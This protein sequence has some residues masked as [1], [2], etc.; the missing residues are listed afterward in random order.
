MPCVRKYLQLVLAL[1]LADHELLVEAI[2]P[3][4][5]QQLPALRTQELRAESQ[6][7]GVPEGRCG[8]EVGEPSP[9]PTGGLQRGGRRE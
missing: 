4:E 9:G 1:H 6:E 3:R 2:C 5:Q 7:P 8:G